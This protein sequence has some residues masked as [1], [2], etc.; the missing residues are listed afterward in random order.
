MHD[1]D[2][3]PEVWTICTYGGRLWRNY[4]TCSKQYQTFLH[5]FRELSYQ[6]DAFLRCR[7]ILTFLCEFLSRSTSEL[8]Y[9]HSLLLTEV[10]PKTQNP[11]WLYYVPYNK[12]SERAESQVSRLLDQLK[13][14]YATSP[15]WAAIG[16][17]SSPTTT[18]LNDFHT[19]SPTHP[20]MEYHHPSAVPCST[21]GNSVGYLGTVLQ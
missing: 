12:F 13:Q 6:L 5:K 15:D 16:K 2:N 20:S 11:N 8:V 21:D 17:S 3:D 1:F 4:Q 10:V 14:M 19:D 7:T 9:E 18:L